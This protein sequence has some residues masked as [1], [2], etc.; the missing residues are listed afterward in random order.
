MLELYNFS[1]STCSI[2]VRLLLGEKY[3]QWEDK[4]LVSSD[5][6]HLSD[7]YLK[8]NPNGVV[9]TLIDNGKPIFESTSILEYLEDQFPESNFRLEDMYMRSQMRSWL[10]FVDVWPALAVRAPS[11]QFGGLMEKFSG[12]SDEEFNA[13]RLKRPLKSEF[14]S[15]FDKNTGFSEV[16][17]FNSFTVLRR[18][19][20]RMNLMLSKSGGPWLIGKNY[21]LADIAVLPLVDRIEDLGLNGLWSNDY[22]SVT[23]WLARAQSRTASLKAFYTG[24]R[25]SDQFP[26]L[27]RGSGSLSN[28]TNKFLGFD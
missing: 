3:L 20:E 17:I 22:P 12:M 13:L 10:V 1:Q 21:S 18:T 4:R 27:V 24:S 23:H 26:D 19:F 15:S 25:L 7:W 16:Q 14:Y 6:Q 2:K 28:W 11:F 9:P 5:H 8:L